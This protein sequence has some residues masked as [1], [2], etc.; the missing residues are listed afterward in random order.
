MKRSDMVSELEQTL[1]RLRQ[2][3]SPDVPVLSV[4]LNL[5]PERAEWQSIEP[6]LRDLLAPVKDLAGSGDLDHDSSMAL[7][8]AAKEA[9]GMAPTLERFPHAG[10]AIFLCESLG[11]RIRLALPRESGIAPS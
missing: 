4:Y 6:R 9:M 2:L 1:E 10:V 3:E 11:L 5:H 7:R 8:A